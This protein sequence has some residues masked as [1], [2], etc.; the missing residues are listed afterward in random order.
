MLQKVVDLACILMLK[1]NKFNEY[2]L[3]VSNLLLAE[4]G[5]SCSKSNG[6]VQIFIVNN[7]VDIN[8]SDNQSSEVSNGLVAVNEFTFKLSLTC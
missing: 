5:Y 4:K 1:S 8:V 7:R 3:L 6:L 2:L